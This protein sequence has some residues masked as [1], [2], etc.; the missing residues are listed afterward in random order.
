[1]E[2]TIH[3]EVNP[4]F[5]SVK[6]VFAD[7]WQDI[8]IGASL[9]V[10]HQGSMVIDLWGGFK[11]PEFTQRWQADTL[12]NVYSTT[13]GM[14]TLAF[15]V[16]VDEG[17]VSYEDKVI[18]YWPEFGAEGKQDVTIA[19][20]LSHQAGLCGVESK[21]SVSD[22]YDWDKMVNLLAAQKPL[23]PL[24]E[25]AGYHAVTWGFLPGELV[26]RITGKT[27]RQYFNEKVREPLD[28]DFYIGLPE[29]E[30]DRCATLVGPNRARKKPKATANSVEMPELYPI[31][32]LNP[33]IK[34]FR[35]ACSSE[36]RKAEIAAANG[37]ASARGIA[38]VYAALSMDGELNGRR[39]ISKEAIDLATQN[40]VGDTIDL[41]LG[42]PTRRAR[43]FILNTDNAY[44]PNPDSFGH[45][46]AGG[47]M[48]YA[49][50]DS[51]IAFGYA[52]NQMQ[53]DA[54][55]KPRSRLLTDAVFACL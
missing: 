23:W 18:D 31:A 55:A 37:Q 48:G 41:V 36:W 17:K 27:L 26:R 40:E 50:R 49:D 44:G 13:K 2:V 43:G 46:G 24:G 6:T 39:I 30:F 54:A 45:A 32:L 51:Q 38:T 34:P 20:L 8:E 28:A 10:Y 1:M 16:L 52:M 53:A 22:L 3:G 9:C 35:D 11:D 4:Q 33:S 25:G 7:L 21:L 19:Q 47:S 15:A 42:T 29:S 14:G 5:E 12:V